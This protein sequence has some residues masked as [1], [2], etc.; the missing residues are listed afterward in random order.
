MGLM[1]ARAQPDFFSAQIA[2]ARR[3]YLELP[4]PAARGLAVVCGGCEHCAADYEIHRRDFPYWSIEFVAQGRG[5]LKLGRQS[6]DLMAGALYAYGPGVSQD[7]VSDPRDRLVKYFVD[8]TGRQ[9]RALLTESGLPP[10]GIAQTSAPGEIMEIFDSLIRN[11]LRETPFTLRLS[12]LLLEQLAVKIAE[13]SVPYGAASTAAF[14][15]YQRCRHYLETHWQR[16]RSLEQIARECHV[17]A[18]H[19][20]RLFQRFDHQSPYQCLLRLKMQHAAARLQTSD[21]TIK[22][23][24]DELGFGDPFHFSRVFKAVL[25]VSPARLASVARREPARRPGGQ[26]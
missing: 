16:L 11:G 24:A 25:G 8:F 6:H 20:C 2:A 26:R 7:I 10:G 17:A 18:A 12:A 22:Q 3:F 14:A 5:W 15:T 13:T 1:P 19:L 4:P 9:A 23:I 21:A